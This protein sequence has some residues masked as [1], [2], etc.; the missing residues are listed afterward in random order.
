MKE[1][2]GTQGEWDYDINANNRFDI[3]LKNSIKSIAIVKYGKVSYSPNKKESE[4]N[5][6][7]ISAAPDLLHSLQNILKSHKKGV[8]ILES[9]GVLSTDKYIIESEAAIEKA[10][11]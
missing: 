2:K 4:A 7:L 11:K 9:K 6:K 1:F 3:Y 5:A 8:E 10:L